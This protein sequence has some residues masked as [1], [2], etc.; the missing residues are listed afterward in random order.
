MS[1]SFVADSGS[2][3]T[4]IRY[5]P[6]YRPTWMYSPFLFVFVSSGRLPL[7]RFS[8]RTVALS[9]TFPWAS[10]TVPL[11]CPLCANAEDAT[12][13][14]ARARVHVVTVRR[15]VMPDIDPPHGG[16]PQGSANLYQTSSLHRGTFVMR[17]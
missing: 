10:T 15:M 14:R 4:V 7:S 13:A 17:Y 3:L 12:N 8:I 11:I 9:T 6:G 5:L 1:V 2:F 16:G